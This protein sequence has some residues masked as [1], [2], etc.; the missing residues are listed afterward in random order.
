[1]SSAP[2]LFINDEIYSVEDFFNFRAKCITTENF[3]AS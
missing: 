3:Y 2:R 1:M